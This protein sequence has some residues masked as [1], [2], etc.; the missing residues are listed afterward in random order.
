MPRKRNSTPDT[1]Q[2]NCKDTK[3]KR[4]EN[5]KAARGNRGITQG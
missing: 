1:P 4:K 5:L 3:I 2:W